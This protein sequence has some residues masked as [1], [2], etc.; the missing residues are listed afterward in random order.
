M[1]LLIVQTNAPQLHKPQHKDV[2][3]T[4]YG[5]CKRD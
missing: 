5:C 2:M 4:L 3:V 1:R